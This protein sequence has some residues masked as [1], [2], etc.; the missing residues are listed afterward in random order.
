MSKV[1][2]ALLKKRIKATMAIICLKLT[3]PGSDRDE[4]EHILH[5]YV[6]LMESPIDPALTRGKIV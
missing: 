4:A 1:E 2:E 3:A 5:E 6:K